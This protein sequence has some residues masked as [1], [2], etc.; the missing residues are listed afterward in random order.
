[1]SVQARFVTAKTKQYACPLINTFFHIAWASRLVWLKKDP[2]TQANTLEVNPARVQAYNAMNN[3][4]QFFFLFEAFWC[5]VNWDDAYETRAIWNTSFY[6]E[7][8]K[9]NIGQ[10]IS[11]ADYELKR[12]GEIR[13]NGETIEAEILHAFG[14]FDLVWD[15]KVEKRPKRYVFPYKTAA[16]TKLGKAILPVLLEKRSRGLWSD[17]NPFLIEGAE[18]RL[19]AFF[20]NRKA[21]MEEDKDDLPFIVGSAFNPF[22]VV[23]ENKAGE[24]P[25]ETTFEVAFRLVLPDLQVK[26]R[27]F[28]IVLPFVPGRYEFRV[29]LDPKCYRD[30]AI[31]GEKTLFE[32]HEAIQ[33]LFKF[34]DDH[35]FAFYLNGKERYGDSQVYGDSRGNLF[36]EN[37]SEAFKI[38]ELGLYPRQ[39][40]LYLFDFGDNWRFYITVL[41][42]QPDGNVKGAY[43]VLETVGKVPKQYSNW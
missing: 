18:E 15:E 20:K 12:N 37:P 19:E 10:A 16:I 39:S 17:L 35:L 11:I 36:D 26:K 22:K 8:I 24:S 21:E 43:E 29:A 40:I 14:L 9:K 34:D 27:L 1:M 25:H 28:P 3:D 31:S 38:G 42:I 7:L 5:Y 23:T 4:E 13:Y 2:R 32:L 30:I 33:K 41:G 6:K